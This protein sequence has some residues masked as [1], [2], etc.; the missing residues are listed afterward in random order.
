MKERKE[1]RQEG[2]NKKEGKKGKQGERLGESERIKVPFTP[3][4]HPFS[5]LPKVAT[6]THTSL[7]AY[8]WQ[9]ITEKP[10]RRH[11]PADIL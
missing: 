10:T 7:L 1:E 3:P 5:S 9:I 2:R 4:F 8:T 11:F 6:V